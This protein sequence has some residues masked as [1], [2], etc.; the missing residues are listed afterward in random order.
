MSNMQGHVGVND[1]FWIEIYTFYCPS[2]NR[3]EKRGQKL[4]KSLDNPKLLGRC[5]GDKTLLHHRQVQYCLTC[6]E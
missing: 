6:R 3:P 1:C 5:F 2:Q 4:T